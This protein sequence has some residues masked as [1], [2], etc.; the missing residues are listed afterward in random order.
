[1]LSLFAAASSCY[2]DIIQSLTSKCNA[3]YGDFLASSD[4]E[5]FAG[6]V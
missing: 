6:Q 2:D 1:M 4:G 5:G 3:V